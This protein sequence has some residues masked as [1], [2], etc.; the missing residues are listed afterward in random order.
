M[1]QEISIEDNLALEF[2]NIVDT[3]NT[4]GAIYIMHNI[5]YLNVGEFPNNMH[6]FVN[7]AVE[8]V[9][10]STS[11]YPQRF[12]Y[13]MLIDT[14]IKEVQLLVIMHL[15]TNYELSFSKITTHS[16]S[17][18]WEI[19][20]EFFNKAKAVVDLRFTLINDTINRLNSVNFLYGLFLQS[21]E[22]LDIDVF[23]IIN[24]LLL[25]EKTLM[26]VYE[27]NQG[28]DL[29]DHILK[30]LKVYVRDEITVTLIRIKNGEV[31]EGELPSMASV[32]NFIRF[33]EML[34]P[35]AEKFGYLQ[36]YNKEMLEVRKFF[37]EHKLLERKN[38]FAFNK[39][40]K[41]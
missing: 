41:K 40:E 39:E 32:E 8:N 25:N 23:F 5:H 12:I 1:E 31:S 35:N 38:V 34:K 33:F 9:V 30:W 19:E 4:N 28:I 7:Y 14:N 37:I 10:D 6:K 18:N 11:V 27:N 29:K 13:G 22:R 21:A 2:K 3:M 17:P 24:Q 36:E 26:A 16:A 15:F 20:L